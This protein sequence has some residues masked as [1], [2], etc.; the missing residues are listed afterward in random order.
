[1]M[2]FKMAATLKS[3]FLQFFLPFPHKKLFIFNFTK[4]Y[5]VLVIKRDAAMIFII[6]QPLF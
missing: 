2:A 5:V 4:I 3:I 1:M 6:I